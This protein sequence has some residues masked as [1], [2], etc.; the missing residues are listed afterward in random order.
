VTATVV[1]EGYLDTSLLQARNAGLAV[2]ERVS[3]RLSGEAD[4]DDP[5]TVG[6]DFMRGKRGGSFE[7]FYRAS[8]K[9]RGPRGAAF[10]VIL[11]SEK[12]GNDRR[13][14]TLGSSP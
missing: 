14:A 12:G 8:W 11:E 10:E 5:E 6:I 2:P 4:S 7:S 13:S 3:L 9:V 1:N